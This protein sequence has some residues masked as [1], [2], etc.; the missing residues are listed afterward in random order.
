M[1]FFKINIFISLFVIMGCTNATSQDIKE[2]SSNSITVFS[3][4][5]TVKLESCIL[6]IPSRYK[7]IDFSQHEP[8]DLDKKSNP[9]NKFS[10]QSIYFLHKDVDSEDNF[11]ARNTILTHSIEITNN[12]FSNINMLTSKLKFISSKKISTIKVSRYKP[13]TLKNIDREN[14]IQLRNEKLSKLNNI[15]IVNENNFSIIVNETDEYVDEIY[16]MLEEGCISKVNRK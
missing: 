6:K 1:N 11:S 7:L 12:F 4:N 5:Y 13:L 8:N 14:T 2:E 3:D 15:L 16:K 10:Y 9:N